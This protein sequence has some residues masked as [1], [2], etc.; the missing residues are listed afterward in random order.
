MSWGNHFQVW[1]WSYS[2][3]QNWIETSFNQKGSIFLKLSNQ[4]FP[5][6][7]ET[8]SSLYFTLDNTS[9]EGKKLSQMAILKENLLSLIAI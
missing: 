1:L 2:T 8:A 5:T 6:P 4:L 9:F 7:S 3:K